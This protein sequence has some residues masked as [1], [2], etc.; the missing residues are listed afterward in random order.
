M[1]L[2][3]LS[4]TVHD[5]MSAIIFLQGRGI[6]HQQRTC[7]NGH[8][9]VLSFAS[10]R[11]R[12]NIRGCRQDIGIRKDTWLANSKLEFQKLVLFIYCWSKQLTSIS[13][14][15]EELGIS[16][17]TT[18]DWN[19]FLREVCAWRLLQ[20]NH[21]I[22]GEGLHVEIDET[23]ISRRKNNAGRM[24]APQWIFGGVCR[25]TKEVFMYAVPNRTKETLQQ[26]IQES[27]MPGSVIISDMW[28]SYRGIENIAGMSFTHETVNH[29]ANFVDPETGAHTQTIES[30]W[31]VFKRR[32]KRQ[33][34]T[35]RHMVEGYMCEFLWRLK[36]RDDCLFDRIM[37]D[38]AEFYPTH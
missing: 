25:E 16:H 2:L 13:F 28:P 20:T 21:V 24:L 18:V 34:G 29:S 26:V 3:S 32:N 4:T 38:I 9:M 22:G 31:N 23:L 35:H 1:N 30:H 14:C 19:N 27:I 10:D 15:D 5:K 8:A 12:C 6:I 36:F 7:R 33:S 11:W 17:A 37:S